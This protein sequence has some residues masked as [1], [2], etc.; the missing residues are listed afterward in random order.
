M[1]SQAGNLLGR[2]FRVGIVLSLFPL[3]VFGQPQ[4]PT[5]TSSPTE[6]YVSVGDTAYFTATASGTSPFH[7]QWQRNGTNLANGG[8][9]TG[10][11]ATAWTGQTLSIASVGMSDDDAYQVVITNLYGQATSP[12]AM[13]IVGYPPYSFS[14][15]PIFLNA[16]LGQT[17]TFTAFTSGTPPVYFRWQRNGVDIPDD[18]H[19]NPTNNP[20]VIS[21]VLASD[22]GAYSTTFVSNHFGKLNTS[23]FNGNL[24]VLLPP[25]LNQQPQSQTV[26][27]GTNVTLTVSATSA[28]GSL[29]YQWRFNGTN[30]ASAT[31]A[32]LTFTN[33]QPIKTGGYDVVVNN[34]GGAVTSSVA[35]LT[36]TASAP[37]FL[38]PP[39]SQGIPVGQ[40][41]V[42]SATARGSDPLGYE[43]HFNGLPI[44]GATPVL[45]IT[46]ATADN[47][48]AYELIVTNQFGSLTGLVTLAVQNPV[49]IIRQPANLAVFAG[50]NIS[51]VATVVGQAPG[52]QW[53]FNGSPLTDAGRISGSTTLTLNIANVQPGD[54][55]S[56]FIKATNSWTTATSRTAALILLDGLARSVRY[57]NVS[58]PT[59]AAPYL[60]WST[61]ATNIQDAIDV[62]VRGDTILVTNGV[63]STGGRMVYGVSTNRVT[64]DK[65]VTLKSV[66]G[67]DYTLITGS[68]IPSLAGTRCVYLTNGATLI[69]FTLT[70]GGTAGR[71]GDTFRDMSGAGVWC[72]DTSVTISNCIITG[73]SAY[74]YAGGAYQGTL[75]SC[76]VTNNRTTS[77]APGEGG[78]IYSG[79]IYD[80]VLTG[81]LGNSGGGASVSTLIDCLLIKNSASTKGAGANESTLIGCNV[82]SNALSAQISSATGGGVYGGGVL[83]S[84]VYYNSSLIASNWTN[85]FVVN[86]CLTPAPTTGFGNLTNN[87]VFANLPGGDL[88][89]SSAS[90]CINSGNNAFVA[91]DVDKAGLPRIAGGTVDIGAYEYQTPGSLLSY[92]WAQ[93]YGLPSDGSA[94]TADSDGDGLNNWQEWKSGTIP[95]NAASVL[96]LASPVFTNQPVG[97]VVKWQSVSG[98]AYYIQRSLNLSAGFSSI[99]SNLTGQTGTTS[100]TDTSATNGG[101]Y[102]YRVGVQ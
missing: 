55:G 56:Y 36:V 57:V 90:P 68:K 98:I 6:L 101:S 69:G 40:T 94:D 46:N 102:F 65:A 25:N 78:G 47:S 26:L 99:I 28:N 8:R 79:V 77:S 10:A 67:P 41:V 64:V 80:S 61:A 17:A 1:H 20:L 31:A 49:Y 50:S 97:M 44:P 4:P 33:V 15:N 91:T 38:T 3:K 92:A 48:G 14:V 16:K 37:W 74:A 45:T 88:R 62:A 60:N 29:T 7:F 72:E 54:A 11:D 82:L 24:T 22:A 42:F 76:L 93:Q 89:L 83:N 66:N 19:I 51:F 53:Y 73:C 18:G 39:H 75:V 32:S 52:F 13:L 84:I 2:F 58:N 81:N 95:T 85:S 21:P 27:A 43:W 86:S 5:I 34:S 12:P 71:I 63:Y 35:Q 30:L 96:Q 23:G 70:N 9:Y 100:Y 87:P 59:P